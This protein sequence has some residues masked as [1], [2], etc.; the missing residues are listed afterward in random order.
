MSDR[1]NVVADDLTD[2]IR[3]PV[4]CVSRIQQQAASLLQR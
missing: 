4:R 1:L 2:G 3:D